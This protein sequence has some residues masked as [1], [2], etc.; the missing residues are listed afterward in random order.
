MDNAEIIRAMIKT[1]NDFANHRIGWMNTINGLLFAGVSFA[2]GKPSGSELIHFFC[3]IGA[4]I[5]V[6]SFAGVMTAAISICSLFDWWQR[7]KP[8]DYDG[9][10]VIGT[11]PPRNIVR[12]FAPQ[13]FLP[14]IFLVAWVMMFRKV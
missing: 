6:F 1:E 3:W 14:L 12:Y 2:W 4:A 5:C 7:H 8:R 11:P 13:N 10:D 9:P